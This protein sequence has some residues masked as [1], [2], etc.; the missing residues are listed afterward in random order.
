MVPAVFLGSAPAARIET[1]V[2]GA[3]LHV[4]CVVEAAVTMSSWLADAARPAIE[5]SCCSPRC[6][7]R[8][9]AARGVCTLR[10]DPAASARSLPAAMESNQQ[11]AAQQAAQAQAAHAAHAQAVQHQAVAQQAYAQV[12]ALRAARSSEAAQHAA[13]VG[14]TERV[15]WRPGAAPRWRVFARRGAARPS[16]SHE[17]GDTHSQDAPTALSDR[18]SMRNR[19]GVC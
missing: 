7:P 12:R 9:R 2:S 1:M 11:A 8:R 15:C 18:L 5:R 3:E 16:S 17:S 13:A 4:E 14:A 19:L 10:A 6:S